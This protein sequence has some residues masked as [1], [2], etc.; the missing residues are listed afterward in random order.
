MRH[1]VFVAGSRKATPGGLITNHH[2]ITTCCI[3]T[4]IYLLGSGWY[5]QACKSFVV[6]SDAC[7]VCTKVVLSSGCIHLSGCG[8]KAQQCCACYSHL[9]IFNNMFRLQFWNRKL[10]AAHEAAWI[11]R[12][13]LMHMSNVSCCVE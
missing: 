6:V 13:Q 12:L 1:S 9:I 2:Q 10:A 5:K 7:M 3:L 8:R 4:L 11:C